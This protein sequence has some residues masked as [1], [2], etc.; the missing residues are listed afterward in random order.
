L[1]Q[2]CE[3]LDAAV[4][5]G[6]GW[7]KD[8]TDDQLLEKLVSLNHQRAQEEK[9]GIIKYLRPDFQIPQRKSAP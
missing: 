4:F 1:K 2:L 3:H 7:P 5:E 6:Y 9:Q 8:L